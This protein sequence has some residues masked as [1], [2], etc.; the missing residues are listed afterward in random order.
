MQKHEPQCK[1]IDNFYFDPTKPIGKGAFATVY[2]AFDESRG[3]QEVAVKMIPASKLLES[4]EQ[5]NLFM[6]EIEV[7][8]KIKGEH[9]VQ[10]IDV[11][12]TTNNLYIFT[13]YCDGGDL[14]K[15]VKA[16]K[17]FTETEGLS[18]LKQIADAFIT[19]DSL[20]IYNNKGRKVAFMH[21]DIKP[22]NV[23]FHKGQVKLADFGFAKIIDGV[24]QDARKAHTLLGTPLYMAPQILNDEEYS[25]KCDIWSAGVLAYQLIV[26][27][28]P[29]NGFT[30]PSLYANIISKPL[31][32]PKHIS[33]DTKDLLSKML[34]IKEENRITWKE[35]YEHRALKNIHIKTS[36]IENNDDTNEN[37]D[38]QHGSQGNLVPGQENYVSVI[39]KYQQKYNQSPFGQQI[40][41]HHNKNSKS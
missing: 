1:K 28:L 7:L 40:P 22:A 18:I 41:P 21:R 2:K 32:F 12:R 23:L 14:E 15:Q 24:D 16:K 4:E 38:M 9:I 36:K 25:V 33:N 10:L 39:N 30:V 26:G 29:W 17:T 13:E 3:N 31:E 11:K 27:K 35:V 19:L 8:R 6:R 37:S 5:Y 20:Q 34:Q